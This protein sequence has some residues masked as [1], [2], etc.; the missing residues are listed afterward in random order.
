MGYSIDAMIS[1]LQKAEELQQNHKITAQQMNPCIS[2]LHLVG[3]EIGCYHI[4]KGRGYI[5]EDIDCPPEQRGEVFFF[6]NDGKIELDYLVE[7][8]EILR[9]ENATHQAVLKSLFWQKWSAIFAG[10]CALIST[11]TLIY[12]LLCSCCR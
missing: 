7:K 2:D 5:R 1:V 4:A 3:N 11:V 6:S 9:R 8:R 10:T 12:N